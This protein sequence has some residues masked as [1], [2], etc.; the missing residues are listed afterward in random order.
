M[1]SMDTE[2]AS[3]QL[4][5]R[6]LGPKAD[7]SRGKAYFSFEKYLCFVEGLSELR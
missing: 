6:L 7:F 5:N 4:K 2:K 1:E 3:L